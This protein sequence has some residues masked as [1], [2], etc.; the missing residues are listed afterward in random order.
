LN[1]CLTKGAVALKDNSIRKIWAIYANY[2]IGHE[3][4][5]MVDALMALAVN[6][7]DLPELER[8]YMKDVVPVLHRHLLY[9][10]FTYDSFWFEFTEETIAPDIENAKKHPYLMKC[11]NEISLV[12]QLSK[13]DY[14][15]YWLE[16]KNAL[17]A[18]WEKT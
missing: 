16:I 6:E 17:I 13:K 7:N 10:P 9:D 11:I 18:R 4:E 15:S 14:R 5:Y 2:L 8:I 1:H 3:L 12:Y